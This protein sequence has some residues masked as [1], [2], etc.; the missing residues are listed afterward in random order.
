MIGLCNCPIS[1]IPLQP[2]VRF[3]LSDFNPTEYLMVMVMVMNEI[4]LTPAILVKNEQTRAGLQLLAVKGAK[5]GAKKAYFNDVDLLR[6]RNETFA[7]L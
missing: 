1:G 4:V 7:Q 2:T 6:M 3:S 5:K